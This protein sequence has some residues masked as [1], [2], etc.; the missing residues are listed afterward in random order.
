LLAVAGG[1][2]YNVESIPSASFPF[3]T[4]VDFEIYAIP[5]K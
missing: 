3:V 4:D 2:M 1:L 5:M